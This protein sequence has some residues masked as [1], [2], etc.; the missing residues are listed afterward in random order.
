MKGDVR[1]LNCGQTIPPGVNNC[2]SC[3]RWRQRALR[4]DTILILCLPVMAVLFVITGF[5]V[6]VHGAKRQ[7]LADQWSRQGEKDLKSGHPL[8]AVDDFRTGLLYSQDNGPLQL[9]LAGA[10][11]AANRAGEARDYLLRLWEDNPADGA[12]NLELGRIALRNGNVTQAIR[13]YHSAID[14]VWPGGAE[15]HRR[16]IR[17]EL[18]EALIS[19]GFRTEALAE[20]VVLS[21]ETPDN[22]G[23]RAEVGSL[24]MQAHDYDAALK[25]FQRATGLDH[26][27]EAAWKG[28][29]ESAYQMG[30]YRLAR[31]Y[32]LRALALD[33]R[34]NQV[35][36]MLN[37]S[38][39][40]LE[41]DPFSPHLPTADRRKRVIH[42]YHQALTRLK[43]CAQSQGQTLT[44]STASTPL[45][46]VYSAAVKLNS[47]ATDSALRRDPDLEDTLMGQAFQMEQA[48]AKACGAPKGLDL[49]ILLIA[50]RNGGPH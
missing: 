14:G 8:A 16:P 36:E 11:F 29:G 3:A 49:A 30:D 19:R 17:K 39:F 43:A 25:Q 32:L 12:V 26:R 4:Q 27:L 5:A 22:A 9:Q 42:A 7:A 47:N 37:T 35:A 45:Q 2:P 40:V 6:K 48:A 46:T 33:A 18:Y 50:Q 41:I 15:A 20:L 23:L 28:A 38:D 10:L 24:F 21:E 13:Y 31:R 44:A 1:C 34:D